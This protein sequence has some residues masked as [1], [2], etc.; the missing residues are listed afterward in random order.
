MSD[1]VG[2]PGERFSHDMAHNLVQVKNS[3]PIR[4]LLSLLLTGEL[5]W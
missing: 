3:L 2:N 5:N 4:S 1:L